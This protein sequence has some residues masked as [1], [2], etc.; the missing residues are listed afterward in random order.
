MKEKLEK[1]LSLQARQDAITARIT[2]R[3]CERVGPIQKYYT[4]K[5]K[6]SFRS[7]MTPVSSLQYITPV[8]FTPQTD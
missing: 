8:P 3:Q 4:E 1:F 5:E 6:I 7:K 2:C